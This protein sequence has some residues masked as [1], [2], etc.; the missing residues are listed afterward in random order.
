MRSGVLLEDRLHR[1]GHCSQLVY[2]CDA[3]SVAVV[4]DLMESANAT[5]LARPFCAVHGIYA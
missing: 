4:S 3:T 2:A 1:F 5:T